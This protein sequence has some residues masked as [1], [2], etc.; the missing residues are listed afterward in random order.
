MDIRRDLPPVYQGIHLWQATVYDDADSLEKRVRVVIPVFDPTLL[1]GPCPW[2]PRYFELSV[3]VSEGADTHGDTE[4]TH[5]EEIPQYFYPKK[6]D[7]ALVA[8]DNIR[9]PWIIVWWPK[10]YGE[11]FKK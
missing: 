10:D 9:A 6:G 7:Y 5:Y 3:K 8:L 2:M 11:P 1:W 4:P